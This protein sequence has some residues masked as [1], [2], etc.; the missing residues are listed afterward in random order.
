MVVEQL[1]TPCYLHG[2]VEG[3]TGWV[4]GQVSK[5]LD[6]GPLPACRAAPLNGQHVVSEDGPKHQLRQVWLG[7]ERRGQLSDQVGGLVER[8]HNGDS[9]VTRQC[10]PYPYNITA[11]VTGKHMMGYS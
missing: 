4:K 3:G 1:R 6:V 2:V 9:L 10:P 8:Q 11:G 5:R 7:L